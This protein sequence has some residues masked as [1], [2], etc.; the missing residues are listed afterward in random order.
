MKMIPSCQPPGRPRVTGGAGF[1]RIGVM[2]MLALTGL[3]PPMA[4]A[5]KPKENLIRA[6]SQLASDRWR[7]R[8]HAQQWL[9]RQKS[10]TLSP[11]FSKL[12]QTQII[13]QKTRLMRICLQ[14][15]LSHVEF[16]A[17]PR[18]LIGINF[19]PRHLTLTVK[20]KIIRLNVAQVISVLPG[21]P[22]GRVLQS[23]D[24]ILALNSH[25][26]PHGTN[27]YTFPLML[28][29]YPPGTT[30]NLLVMRGRK[31]RILPIQLVGVPAS[32]AAIIPLM[33]QRDAITDKVIARYWPWSHPLILAAKPNRTKK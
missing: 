18:P 28:G 3:N 27:E 2:A 14:A 6:I 29:A 15:L 12:L 9:L 17:G 7:V 11:L 25:P 30:V 31:L 21:F 33:Q 26:F 13:E 22:A 16:A 10:S 4:T 5:A 20:K 24:I 23:G 19:F 32:P 8:S 1:I